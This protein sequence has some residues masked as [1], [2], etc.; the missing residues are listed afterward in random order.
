MELT[1][2]LWRLTLELWRLTLE[3]WRLTLELLEAHPGAVAD[4]FVAA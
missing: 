3:L 1:L 4:Y 2:E